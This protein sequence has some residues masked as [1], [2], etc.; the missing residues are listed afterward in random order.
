M[1]YSVPADLSFGRKSRFPQSPSQ[2]NHCFQS[3]HTLFL[4]PDDQ[5]FGRSPHR[6]TRVYPSGRSDVKLSGSVRRY[7]R[8]TRLNRYASAGY[9][10]PDS[11]FRCEVLTMQSHPEAILACRILLRGRV[12]GLGVRPGV[13]R[14]AKLHRIL[15][16]VQNHGEGVLIHAEATATRI[17][18]F[19]VSLPASLPRLADCRIISRIPAETASF[20]EFEIREAQRD[21]QGES[22]E[23]RTEVPLDLV[24]CDNCQS[25]L[26]A[27]SCR[28][29]RHPFISCTVC[30][31]RY[32]IVQ[33]M[34]FERSQTSMRHF[35]LCSECRD[36][37]RGVSDRRFHSQ[38]IACPM[39]GP[40]LTYR[41]L[42]ECQGQHT[43]PAD[44]SLT[45]AVELLM[46]GGILAVKGIGGYQLVCD[47]TRDSSIA[48]LRRRKRRN[49]KPLAV[50]IPA[51]HAIMDRLSS[52]ERLLLR[53]SAGPIVITENVP[54]QSVSPLVN[55]CGPSVGIFLA[56]TPLH[57]LLLDALNRPL[58][59]TSANHEGQPIV[60]E[61]RDSVGALCRLADA[62]LT[63]DRTIERPIDDSV[64]RIIADQA[65]RIRSARGLAPH[66]IAVSPEFRL[67]AVGGEQKVACAFTNGSLAVL[68]PWIGDLST[69]DARR[70]FVQHVHDLTMLYNFAPTRIVHDLHPDYFTSR[71]AEDQSAATMTVQHHHAHVVAT[72]VE[73]N[74]PDV[75]MLGLAFDGTGY[76]TDG[77]IWGGE[78]L[79]VTRT[80]CHRIASLYPF[81]LPGGERAVREPWRVAVSIMHQAAPE[82]S[83]DEM[84]ALLNRRRRCDHG[85]LSVR[86]VSRIRQLMELSVSEPAGCV[87]TTSL[88]RLFDGMASLLL[89]SHSADFEGHPAMMLEAECTDV[90]PTAA[91]TGDVASKA[92]PG[93]SI[94]SG[95]GRPEI[96][97][98]DRK[99]P[100]QFQSLASET[101]KESIGIGEPLRLSEVVAMFHIDWRP[102]LRRILEALRNDVPPSQLSWLFHDCVAAAS[103]KIAAFFPEL[104]VVAGGGC[105]QNR[106]LT[107]RLSV[108]LRRCGR[109]PLLPGK[110]PPNDNGLAVGQLAVAVAQLKKSGVVM[111]QRHQ[112]CSPEASTPPA[113]GPDLRYGK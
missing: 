11:L 93:R 17:E 32:S 16:F 68:G 67:L 101:G 41:D 40:R 71:W 14:A 81:L 5:F 95:D 99:K 97:P 6:K 98:A 37:Y 22:T 110:I 52:T 64:V 86:D 29:F 31:P 10:V 53:S 63:H 72:A 50:M 90:A 84:A 77:T 105:F 79:R 57:T 4:P 88:G 62:V 70:R 39:C 23:L 25:E 106:M 55:P 74:L 44:N 20:S 8:F 75:P 38:T 60:F 2:E 109:T 111:E 69:T 30:G 34:P 24:L 76:G 51:D 92:G 54:V 45:A 42:Q 15:G 47:A 94:L 96:I 9:C 46:A 13:V 21:T 104:P 59:V 26:R 49:N 89:G 103:A 27:P 65:V 73:H 28:R 87:T 100:T 108:H 66:E 48:E 113:F 1:R 33:S 112:S 3:N 85:R 78:V 82:I 91:E 35:P 56:T 18:A 58:V 83:S 7:D 19:C 36:E 102:M 12:Q 61:D 80:E 43:A 107:D